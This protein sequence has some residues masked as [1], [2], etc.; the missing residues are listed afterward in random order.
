MNLKI[1]LAGLAIPVAGFWLVTSAPAA[2][3]NATAS[4]DTP[5]NFNAGGG[6]GVLTDGVIGGNDWLNVPVFQYL[7]WQDAGYVPVD[8]G[9][10]SLLPQPQLTFDLGGLFTLDSMTV[11]YM[12]DYPPG[13]SFANIRAP[14]DLTISFSADGVAGPFGGAF[15]ETGFDDGPEG[16]VNPGGGEARSLTIDL[17]GANANAVRL[18]FRN[19]G[20]WTFLSEVAFQGTVVP[21]PGTYALLALGA[22]GLAS[23]RRRW[24]SRRPE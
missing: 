4:L 10:D 23:F 17:A 21:E 16:D 1:M 6:P 7:G 15:V 11:N 19:D 2:P 9:S 18:D 20:E 24:Q 8:S 13:T 22:L 5:A 3:I 14:N 12:V